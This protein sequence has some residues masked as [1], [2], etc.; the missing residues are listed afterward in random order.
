MG[1]ADVQVANLAEGNETKLQRLV[2]DPRL[3]RFDLDLERQRQQA[4]D[5]AV[6]VLDDP[7]GIGEDSDEP[8]RDRY[9]TGFLVNL[10]SDAL[11]DRFV[12]VERTSGNAPGAEIGPA[13]HEQ[14]F[15]AV[16]ERDD[17]D[18]TR[19]VR[20][21]RV[22]IAVEAGHTAEYPRNETGGRRPERLGTGPERGLSPARLR[23]LRRVRRDSSPWGSSEPS[24][25]QA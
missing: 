24:Q 23:Q 18:A 15:V 2:T 12:L 19:V 25:S 6:L 3:P 4:V 8:C 20:G 13:F 5:V 14:R 10:A 16:N 17:A 21:G 11:L 22:R 9:E 1:R 7:R